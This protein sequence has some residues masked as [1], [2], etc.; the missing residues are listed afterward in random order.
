MLPNTK[1]DDK[2]TLVQVM[3][4]CH[5]ATSHY[6]HQC[7]PR[8]ISPYDM[9]RLQ[10]LKTDYISFQLWSSTSHLWKIIR[11]DW[12]NAVSML[13]IFRNSLTIQYMVKTLK[14]HVIHGDLV[15]NFKYRKTSNISPTLV[16]NT[17]RPRRDGHYFPMTFSNAFSWM[18]IYKFWLRFISLKFVPKGLINNIPALVQIMAWLLNE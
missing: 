13:F 2:S 1:V 16:G 3:P 12:E 18:K 17:L 4:W 7:W 9:S 11:Y 10:W 15:D 14:C 5:H 8:S 6:L